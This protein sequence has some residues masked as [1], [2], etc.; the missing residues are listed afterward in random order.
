MR[1]SNKNQKKK[2]F[3][4]VYKKDSLGLFDGG[5]KSSVFDTEVEKEDKRRKTTKEILEELEED[6]EDYEDLI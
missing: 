3:N 1:N 4:N 5:F 2:M 6:F